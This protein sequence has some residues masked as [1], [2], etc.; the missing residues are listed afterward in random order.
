VVLL[1]S[2]GRGCGHLA[3]HSG[4]RADQPHGVPGEELAAESCGKGLAF[5]CDV[6]GKLVHYAERNVLSRP[7]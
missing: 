7:G 3:R 4:N 6:P 5:G 1:T 2:D